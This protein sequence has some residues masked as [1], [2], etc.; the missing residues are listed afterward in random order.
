MPETA[1]RGACAMNR[2]WMPGFGVVLALAG[3]GGPA[4]AQPQATFDHDLV[5]RQTLDNV[6]RPGLSRLQGKALALREAIGEA[7]V[8]NTGVGQRRIA[9]AFDGFV[10]AWGR[11]ELLRFGPLT[12]QY[13]AERI[14]FWPDRGGRGL[15]RVK[16]AIAKRDRSVTDAALLAQ[17]SPTAKGL[18]ALDAVLYGNLAH[19]AAGRAFMC[20]YALAI[21]IRLE[22]TAVEISAD[23]SAPDGYQHLW[24]AAGPGN[25]A[26]KSGA[27]RTSV[28]ASVMNT[29]LE[30]VRDD[31]IAG[32]LGFNRT[33]HKTTPPLPFSGRGLKLVVGNLSG[34]LALYADGGLMA[35]LEKAAPADMSTA[36]RKRAQRVRQML[37]ETRDQLAKLPQ[38]QAPFSDPR[39]MRAIVGAGFPL[40]SVRK[41]FAD[42]MSE[43][44]GVPTGF[45]AS[46]GD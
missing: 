24:L 46:D 8:A 41:D 28:L 23:W 31:R 4:S 29:G 14:L 36:V 15:A 38:V 13:R 10:D 11:V 19:D 25:A 45:T 16:R 18:S 26:F 34:L 30:Q 33:R 6:I 12:A 7:C 42:L 44:A 1:K 43:V 3:F 27:E 17:K 5:A 2:W 22:A 37:A 35:A 21:A 40:K 39:Q 32:P 9:V 20:A